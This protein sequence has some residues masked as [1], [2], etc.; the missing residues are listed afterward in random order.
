MNWLIGS[1]KAPRRLHSDRKKEPAVRR[2]CEAPPN[3]K[4]R[5]NVKERRF[6]AAQASTKMRV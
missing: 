6:S 2:N 4:A 1:W 3:V 5:P